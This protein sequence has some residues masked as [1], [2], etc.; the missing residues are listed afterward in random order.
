MTLLQASSSISSIYLHLGPAAVLLDKCQIFL[1]FKRCLTLNGN[2]Y[3]DNFCFVR[4]QLINY[5]RGLLKRVVVRCF[6]LVVG[7]TIRAQPN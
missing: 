2:F 5:G 3:I 1:I 4:P 6:V 7:Q